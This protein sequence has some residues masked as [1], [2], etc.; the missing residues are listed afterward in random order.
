MAWS[1]PGS[2]TNADETY[3]VLA[4]GP[5][6]WQALFHVKRHIGIFRYGPCL[7]HGSVPELPG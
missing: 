1:S 5:G 7:T 2:N 4:Y 6:R 3:Q